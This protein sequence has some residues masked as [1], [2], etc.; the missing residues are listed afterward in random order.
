MRFVPRSILT[1]KLATLN[2]GG[3]ALS[4]STASAHREVVH[5]HIIRW[6]REMAADGEESAL[7]ESFVNSP[8]KKKGE[9]KRGAEE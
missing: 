1:A 8:V 5:V 9:R 6:P 7:V 4:P 2:Q 3:M